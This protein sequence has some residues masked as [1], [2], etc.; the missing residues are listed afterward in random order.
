MEE[1][2]KLW[3]EMEKRRC[4]LTA[5]VI[6]EDFKTTYRR[7]CS[8]SLRAHSNGRCVGKIER[9]NGEMVERGGNEEEK[10]ASG[11]KSSRTRSTR[12]WAT[13]LL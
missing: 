5:S 9:E 6:G 12:A 7:M 10:R 8:S 1:G 4:T 11:A 13:H 2:N 3:L